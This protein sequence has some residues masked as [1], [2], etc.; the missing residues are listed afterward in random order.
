MILSLVRNSGQTPARGRNVG[1]L[2]V[3]VKHIWV[4]E[5]TNRFPPKSENRTNVALSRAKEGLYILGNSE[6][7]CRQSKM[8]RGVVA[9]LKQRDQIGPG[10][11]ISCYLHPDTINIASEPGQLTQISPDGTLI[12]L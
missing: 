8:W 11:P 5:L 7:L 2:N 6:D 4:V 9:E 10:I 12:Q 3:G 1:F